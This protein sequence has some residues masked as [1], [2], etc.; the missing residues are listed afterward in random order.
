MCYSENGNY[1]KQDLLGD[2]AEPVQLPFLRALG[3]S[4]WRE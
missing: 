3:V 2:F 1:L 4:D